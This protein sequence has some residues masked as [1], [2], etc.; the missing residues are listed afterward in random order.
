MNEKQ[1]SQFGAYIKYHR[2]EKKMS[3]RELAREAGI[4]SATVVRLERG[5]YRTPRPET[6][7]GIA[8]ALGL[9]LTDVF[10]MADYV[11]AYDL[12]SLT[13][14]LRAKYG[15][16]PE[17]AVQAVNRYVERIAVEHGLDIGGPLPG[18]DE[19]PTTRAE[20]IP[21]EDLIG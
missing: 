21:P 10:T 7:K 5:H 8:H 9:P 3:G 1:A 11:S 18:E 4:D 19:Q 2:L 14:Y 15:E 17:D 6:L 16:L 12:P 20:D 13:P